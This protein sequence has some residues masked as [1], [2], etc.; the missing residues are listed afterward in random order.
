MI[1]DS[2]IN[3]EL[4]EENARLEEEYQRLLGAVYDACEYVPVLK[5]LAVL[6][7]Y[8]SADEA[9]AAFDRLY[10][11]AEGGEEDGLGKSG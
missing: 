7:N 4:S 3:V 5:D 10:E 8:T 2:W 1:D 6:V 9:I 11:I